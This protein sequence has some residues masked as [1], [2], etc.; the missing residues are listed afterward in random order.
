MTL[1]REDRDTLTVWASAEVTGKKK[2]I[3]AELLEL[4]GVK[5][6]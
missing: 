6:G 1:L 4:S 2:D 3:W 5:Q